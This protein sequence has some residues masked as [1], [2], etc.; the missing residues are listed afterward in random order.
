MPFHFEGARASEWLGPR[1][2][3]PGVQKRMTLVLFY[4][5]VLHFGTLSRRITLIL[6][7]AYSLSILE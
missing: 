7:S 2:S 6:A 4:I 3:F 1:S 5:N